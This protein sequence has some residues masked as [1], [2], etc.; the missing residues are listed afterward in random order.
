VIA[1]STELGLIVKN[2]LDAADRPAWLPR[3][4]TQ[5]G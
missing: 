4:A 3:W 2:W 5:Q 1:G